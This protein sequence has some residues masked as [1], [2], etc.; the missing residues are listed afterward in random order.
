MLGLP[1]IA[2]AAV[3]DKTNA[4][5]MPERTNARKQSMGALLL[6]AQLYCRIQANCHPST[7]LPNDCN[8]S[9]PAIP[10]AACE[11]LIFPTTDISARPK[12]GPGFA[13]NDYWRDAQIPGIRRL[14]RTRSRLRPSGG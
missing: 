7:G 2:C 9:D 1:R 5:A 3:T 14:N 4:I 8:G 11:R 10:S 6:T 12:F 13:R